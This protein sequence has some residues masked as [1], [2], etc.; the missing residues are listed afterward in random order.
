MPI[1]FVMVVEHDPKRDLV[2][3]VSCNQLAEDFSKVSNSTRSRI[4]AFEYALESK[5]LFEELHGKLDKEKRRMQRARMAIPGLGDRDILGNTEQA[6]AIYK[7]GMVKMR[8][9]V[10]K[11]EV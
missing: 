9:V 3:V 10:T 5:G 4:L 1:E 8:G 7:E 6:L 2:T 11:K